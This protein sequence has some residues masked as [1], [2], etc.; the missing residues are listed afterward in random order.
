MKMREWKLRK[1]LE[2][3]HEVMF[4]GELDSINILFHLKKPVSLKVVMVC[5][6]RIQPRNIF[7]VKVCGIERYIN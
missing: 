3:I 2:F 5:C 7:F 6:L 4:Q 1:N